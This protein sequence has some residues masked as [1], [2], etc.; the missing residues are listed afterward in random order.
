MVVVLEI[1]IWNFLKNGAVLIE[2]N[3]EYGLWGTVDVA[4]S[5]HEA[6]QEPL[7]MKSPVLDKPIVTAPYSGP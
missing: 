4:S 1:S 2:V 7:L 3:T 6:K 5:G